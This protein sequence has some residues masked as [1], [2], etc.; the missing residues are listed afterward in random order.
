MT[1]TPSRRAVDEGERSTRPFQ[2]E[3]RTFNVKCRC[4]QIEAGLARFWNAKRF[5]DDAVTGTDT[6]KNDLDARI[7]KIRLI[8]RDSPNSKAGG[9]PGHAL[10]GWAVANCRPPQRLSILLVR[11]VN[12]VVLEVLHLSLAG[13]DF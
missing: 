13:C 6:T 10:R 5:Y 7:R 4:A 12:I 1:A 2:N 11:S 8:R 9:R 3:A